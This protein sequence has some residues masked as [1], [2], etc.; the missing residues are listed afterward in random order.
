M[1]RLA[2]IV[3]C[4][5]LWTTAAVADAPILKGTVGFDSMDIQHS[6]CTAVSGALLAKL[7]RNY[8]CTPGDDHT[9]SGVTA[10]A[11]CKAKKG[12]SEFDLFSTK[13]DCVNER[14]TQL[15]N[16]QGD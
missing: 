11:V 7:T 13:K 1:A 2:A 6:K 4:V 9:A 8:A 16:G 5:V 3:S 14:E 10:V 15:A 12:N